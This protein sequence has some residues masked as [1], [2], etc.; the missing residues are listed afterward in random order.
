V[1]QLL[2]GTTKPLQIPA[3]GVVLALLV[4]RC[5]NEERALIRYSSEERRNVVDRAFFRVVNA[6]SDVLAPSTRRK[7]DQHLI[8]GW[9]L[10]EA[11]RR[12]GENLVVVDA[13]A[14]SD[15]KVW[16]REEG[17]AEV[18][19]AIARDLVRGHR[20]RA[21]PDGLEAAFDALVDALRAELPRLAGFGLAHERPPNT[22]RLRANLIESLTRYVEQGDDAAGDLAS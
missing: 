22:K 12:L 6:F 3:A 9:M 13:R 16:V 18:V 8:S 11:R 20:A 17:E 5:T 2:A 1:V 14:G 19:R 10:Y 7:R 4:D 21:T 15:G